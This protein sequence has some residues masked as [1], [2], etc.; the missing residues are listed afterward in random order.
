MSYETKWRKPKPEE[1]EDEPPRNKSIE[2]DLLTLPP[3]QTV[4]DI[5][6]FQND[7]VVDVD[8]F[9]TQTKASVLVRDKAKPIPAPTPQKTTAPPPP[10]SMNDMMA[11]AN[12]K[13]QEFQNSLPNAL[14]E[15]CYWFVKSDIQQLNSYHPETMSESDLHH[16]AALLKTFVLIFLSLPLC[17]WASYN[18]YYLL[19][20][21]E[22]KV[23]AMSLKDSWLGSTIPNFF[24]EFAVSPIQFFDYILFSWIP[25]TDPEKDKSPL[26]SFNLLCLF[27]FI[28]MFFINYIDNN[29]SMLAMLSFILIFSI[30][31]MYALTSQNYYLMIGMFLCLAPLIVVV[32]LVSEIMGSWISN[33]QL[34]GIIIAIVVIAW[35]KWG[36]MFAAGLFIPPSPPPNLVILVVSALYALIR[37]LISL[38]L[39]PFTIIAFNL[40]VMMYS[41]FGMAY[42][43]PQGMQMSGLFDFI[44]RKDDAFLGGEDAPY[45]KLGLRAMFS[46]IS[47]NLLYVGY[48]LLSFFYLIYGWTQWKSFNV[49]ITL[50]WILAIVI[51]FST[52]AM[53]A[54]S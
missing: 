36:F 52:M 12:T 48:I 25:S 42:F 38:G 28:S 43:E 26:Q 16:D 34:S 33:F 37:L 8:S 20:F 15:L 4:F 53:M 22:H 35:A 17:V 1:V 29:T 21:D 23:S 45:W 41:F 14:Y 13:Y 2:F 31:F 50:S 49:K 40:Y 11:N 32:S 51:G 54:K 18:W 7:P 30:V 5:P 9:V 6:E 24:L 44:H 19:F 10:P 3:L 46:H 27:I 47:G 39:T